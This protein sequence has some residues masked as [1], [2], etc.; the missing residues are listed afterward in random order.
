MTQIDV[1]PFPIFPLFP[2]IIHP[3]VYPEIAYHKFRPAMFD[4]LQCVFG[5]SFGDRL[6]CVNLK[7]IRRAGEP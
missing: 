7:L 4:R 2:H 5:R 6:S 3:V 1:I